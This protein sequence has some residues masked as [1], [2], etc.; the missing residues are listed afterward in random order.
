MNAAGTAE[1]IEVAEDVFAYL[2]ADGT[3]GW[4]NAGLVVGDDGSVL[5]DTLFDLHLT[6]R[7]LD[8]MSPHTSTKPIAQVVNT[9]ANG[10]HCYGN[11]LVAGAGVDVIASVAAGR[12][13]EEVPA[14]L[15]AAMV[16]GITEGTLGEY[17][18]HAFGAFDFDGIDMVEPTVTFTEEHR[19]DA[20]GRPVN[21]FEVG[22]AHT[23]GDI[24]A[25][26]PDDGVLFA[27]DILFIDGTPIMWA[28]PVDGWI[29]AIDRILD[30]EPAVIVP[31]HG[32]LTDADGVR[33]LR[34]YFT[35]LKAMV[36]ERHAAGMS[37]AD[38]IADIDRQIDEG[39]YA[40]W[41]DRERIVVNVQT[42]WSELEPGFVS[43]EVVAVFQQM[44]DNHAGRRGIVS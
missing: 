36:T 7:M 39:P 41:T 31:G 37:V 17:I 30:L 11:Q 14:S 9:H 3:W 5:V 35:D 26:L 8:T 43:P 34:G 27:G 16:A 6:R 2:Q 18:Q 44:A 24:L 13:M 15:L 10:D 42:I 4:S 40:D 28:G 1:L 19:I 23:A 33:R 32:P 12:E 22:P 25:W 21:L 20:G 29:A 38:A